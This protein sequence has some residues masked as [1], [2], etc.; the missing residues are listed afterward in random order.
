MTPE[1]F[2]DQTVADAKALGMGLIIGMNTL[3][4]GDGSS[5][6]PGTYNLN[7]VS[8]RWQMS[9][10]EVER[11][12]TVFAKEPY[13][14]A[15]LD[16]RF[17]PTVTSSNYSASQA[18]RDPGI[19]QPERREGGICEGAGGGETRAATRCSRPAGKDVRLGGPAGEMTRRPVCVG[20]QKNANWYR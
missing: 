6:I 12:G 1:Q 16:W 17:S 5:R 14:C 18:A 11:A 2:R 19:R 9:A 7:T 10:A 15:V 20:S 3:D 8:N 13:V 4:G